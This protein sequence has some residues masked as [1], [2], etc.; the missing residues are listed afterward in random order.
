MLTTA[1]SRTF[2]VEGWHW[3]QR[4]TKGEWEEMSNLSFCLDPVRTFASILQ[5]VLLLFLYL[6]Q[7]LDPLHPKK[8]FLSPSLVHQL[9]LPN[10]LGDQP[11]DP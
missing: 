10:R 8:P 2:D 4:A 6:S 11:N 7:Y 1:G 9:I 3:R 5:V